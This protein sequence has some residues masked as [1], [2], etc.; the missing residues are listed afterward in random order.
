MPKRTDI[1]SI[2]I[3]GAGP[4]LPSPL[5][6]RGWRASARR[7]RGRGQGRLDRR[8]D[9]IEILQHIVVPEAKD[10]KA[11]TL[12]KFSSTR[13]ALG[14]VL[15]A[16]DL[17]D[18]ALL[19]AEEVRDVAIDLDLPTELEAVHLAVAE[20]VPEFALGVGGV[21]TQP[22][23]SGRQKMLPCHNSPSPQPSPARGEGVKA[24]PLN[25]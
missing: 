4:K 2:L 22:P 1:S 16:V 11:L 13:V 25:A 15:P 14:R 12:Q 3:I 20:N 17:D 6:G 7:V 18:Q 24:V 5:R 8:P 9:T 19:G 10:T 21:A 23:R